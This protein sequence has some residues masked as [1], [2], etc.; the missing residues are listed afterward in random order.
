MLETLDLYHGDKYIGQLGY[1]SESD[2]Y[3]VD[4]ISGLERLDIPVWFWSHYP[5]GIPNDVVRSF[6]LDRTMPSRR[7]NISEILEYYG[8]NEYTT[9]GLFKTADGR[10]SRDKFHVTVGDGTQAV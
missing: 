8:L 9:W 1:D 7:H 6:I 10:C 4:L 2:E 3:S 5:G